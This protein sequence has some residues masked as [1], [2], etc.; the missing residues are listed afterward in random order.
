MIRV[1]ENDVFPHPMGSIDPQRDIRFINSEFLLSDLSIIEN[2][3]EKLEKLVMKIQNEKDKKELDVLTKVQGGF[4]KRATNTDHWPLLIQE[5]LIIKG[6]QFLS[7]KPLFF[8]LNIGEKDIE[9]SDQLS[10][11]LAKIVDEKCT[12]TA[13]CAEIEKEISRLEPEDAEDFLKDLN[14]KEPATRKL[15]R[16]SYELLGLIAFFTVGDDECR[17]WT[18]KKNTKAQKAAGVIHSDL[19]KGFIRAEV[20]PYDTLIKEGSLAAC[21]EKGLL[22]LEGK[23]YIV[24]DG[25]IIS[26]RFNV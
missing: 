1:F 5:E 26:V 18:I 19:E 3:I 13:L 2:R 23:E 25:E 4:G 10:S 24:S 15:I 16:V 22:R 11:E 12:V 9:K 7:A 6:F 21:K 8:V 14:I 20:V 17:A